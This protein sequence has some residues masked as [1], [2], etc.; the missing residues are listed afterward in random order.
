MSSISTPSSLSHL[1][2]FLDSGD[3]LQQ[4]FCCYAYNLLPK[5]PCAMPPLQEPHLPSLSYMPHFLLHSLLRALI[6]QEAR[7]GC[8]SFHVSMLIS[9]FVISSCRNAPDERRSRV[10]LRV[11]QVDDQREISAEHMLDSDMGEAVEGHTNGSLL[12]RGR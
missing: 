2:S 12:W 6:V 4:S 3:S 7:K 11:A 5:T 10:A 1:I 8:K 9:I